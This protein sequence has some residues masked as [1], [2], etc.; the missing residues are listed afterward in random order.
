MKYL[1]T[2]QDT[3]GNEVW[4]KG[5]DGS[6]SGLDADLLDGKHASDFAP[7]G[8]G[9]GTTCTTAT[10]DWNNYILTGFYMGSNLLNQCEGGSWRYCIVMRHNDLWISQTMMDFNGTGVFQRNKINGTWGSWRRLDITKLSQLTNDV[11][12]TSNALIQTVSN[13]TPASPVLG[14]VW[15]QT[16]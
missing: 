1:N 14:Q 6:N 15:I 8:Y 7:A 13:T 9:L 11:G 4:N 3:K 2:L 16:I 12:F 5:N 10:G